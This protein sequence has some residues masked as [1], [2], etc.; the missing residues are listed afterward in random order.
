MAAF[1]WMDFFDASG[2]A[3]SLANEC[4]LAGERR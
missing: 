3:I 4:T 1:Q 2:I